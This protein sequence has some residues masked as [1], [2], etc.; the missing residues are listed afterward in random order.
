MF[1]IRVNGNGII[2]MGHVMRCLSIAASLK[3]KGIKPVFLTSCEESFDTINAQGYPV[4]LLGTDNTQMEKE[5][6][7]WD[8]YLD[9]LREEIGESE[10]TVW[11]YPLYKECK[12]RNLDLITHTDTILLDS[13]DVTK[14]YVL[15]LRD[16]GK[17]IYLDDLGKSLG[18]DMVINYNI[19][20]M[21]LKYSTI[22][23]VE[24][25]VLLGPSF[26]PLRREFV[27]DIEYKCRKEVKN[28]LIT[29]GGSDP[30]FVSK[31]ILNELL[32]CTDLIEQEIVFHVVSGPYNKFAGQ[33]KNIYKNNANVVI[34]ENVKSM[35][36]L[37]RNSDIVISAAGST[38]YEV[39]AIGVPLI[40]FFFVENQRMIAEML[41]IVTSVKNVGDFSRNPARRARELVEIVREYVYNEEYRKKLYQE[42][43]ELV[44]GQGAK[45]IA[46][47]MI[48]LS[49]VMPIIQKPKLFEQTEKS[50]KPKRKYTR[51]KKMSL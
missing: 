38:V 37:M 1:I 31:M 24:L 50:E 43:K 11:R 48:E 40:S 22:P 25:K 46:E 45:R 39:C 7:Y 16:Y 42:E 23:N 9:E 20:G 49:Q 35:K 27:E 30:L 13:Y 4:R 51:R 44:D 18:T 26:I 32:R 33:L 8:L 29:T 10:E 3:E 6:P 19:Y 5:F 12:A 17:I 2:G 34:H 15:T 47:N 14:E 41:P 21:G 36:A 28:I